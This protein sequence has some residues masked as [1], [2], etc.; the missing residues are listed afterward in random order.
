MGSSAHNSHVGSL[1]LVEITGGGEGGGLGRGDD[2]AFVASMEISPITV[3]P[4]VVLAASG[5]AKLF[6]SASITEATIAPVS[7]VIEAVMRT[8]PAST[9]M[10]T[11][12][13]LTPATLAMEICSPEVR[14]TTCGGGLGGSGEGGGG[15][16][17]S[18]GSG[19]G[20]GDG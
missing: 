16:G 11:A 12:P 20:G 6:S 8:L 10:A 18:G 19:G 13:E 5:V 7:R 1:V 15:L 17:G 3:M 14:R 9:M 4:R 2:G